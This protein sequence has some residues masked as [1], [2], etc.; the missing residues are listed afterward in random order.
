[1]RFRVLEAFRNR[2]IL[3]LIA[4]DVASRGLDI[5]RVT[6]VINYD[7]PEDPE[8]YVHRIGRTGRA[9]VAGEA[10]SLVGSRDRDNWRRVQSATGFTIEKVEWRA[11][12][13]ETRGRREPERDR[14]RR[15][16]RRAVERPRRKGHTRAA[17]K[18]PIRADAQVGRAAVPRGASAAKGKR[19]RRR[20]GKRPSGG[21]G[22]S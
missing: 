1:M 11:P 20:R 4:T 8:L 21:G 2:E 16:H 10:I 17:P 19:R 12:A 9:N 14:G 15:P 5:E 13:G 6:R 22:V 18:R 3:T 7:I